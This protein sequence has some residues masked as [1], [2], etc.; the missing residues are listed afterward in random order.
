MKI[1]KII[2]YAVVGIL[3]S[4]IFFGSIIYFVFFRNADDTSKPLKTYEYTI[5][6]F[7]TNLGNVRSFFKGKLVVEVTDKKLLDKFPENNARIRDR[8]I[9]ILIS[10][11]PEQIMDPTGQQNL[12]IELIGEISKLMETDQIS[13]LYFIDYIIQ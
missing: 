13:N 2:L 9:E 12:R 11:K 10:K 5:G 1:K 4:A 7:T 3:L 8:V 6:D